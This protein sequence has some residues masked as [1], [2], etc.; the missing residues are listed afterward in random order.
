MENAVVCYTGRPGSFPASPK[1]VFRLQALSGKKN[2]VGHDNWRDS[3]SPN[4]FLKSSVLSK[5]RTWCKREELELKKVATGLHTYTVNIY[6]RLL[7]AWS[8]WVI[9]KQ[10]KCWQAPAF[11]RLNIR[12][13]KKAELNASKVYFSSNPNVTNQN[14]NADVKGRLIQKSYS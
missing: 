2:G 14:Q 13:K 5:R 4:R 12:K 6:K 7:R 11:N 8:A 9:V 1:C 3:A 10:N